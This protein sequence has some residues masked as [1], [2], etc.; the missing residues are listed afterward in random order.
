VCVLEGLG[1]FEIELK[2]FGPVPVR[3]GEQVERLDH[4]RIRR[5]LRRVHEA[6]M[7][8]LYVGWWGHALGVIAAEKAERPRLKI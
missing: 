3:L 6:L 5:V 2:F 8:C 1:G 7:R 4:L